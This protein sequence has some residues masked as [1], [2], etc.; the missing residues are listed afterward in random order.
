MGRN[1]TRAQS[2][3]DNYIEFIERNTHDI[4]EETCTSEDREI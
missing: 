2:S 4:Y 1:E 3:R